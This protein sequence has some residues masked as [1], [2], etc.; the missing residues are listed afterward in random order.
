MGLA[1]EKSNRLFLLFVRCANCNREQTKDV[2]V[3]NEAD[4]PQDGEEL[5]ESAFLGSIP[6]ACTEC[7][8][9]IGELVGIG[10]GDLI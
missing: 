4:A 2:L 7:D 3:P 10:G 8:G 1:L 9:S 6:F 5:L